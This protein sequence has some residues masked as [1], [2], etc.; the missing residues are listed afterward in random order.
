MKDNNPMT[1]PRKKRNI[2]QPPDNTP[3]N[4]LRRDTR[5]ETLPMTLDSVKVEQEARRI[6]R[7]AIATNDGWSNAMAG[8]SGMMDKRSKTEYG[9]FQ[10]V[11]DIELEC[12]YFGDG[13]GAAIVDML[14]EDMTKEWIEIAAEGSTE[15]GG[16]EDDVSEQTKTDIETV[17]GELERLDAET[18]YCEALKWARLYGGSCLVIGVLDGK[19][20]DQPLNLNRIQDIDYL[21]VVDRS[22]IYLASSIFQMDPMKHGFGEPIILRMI[23]YVGTR[24]IYQDVHV[25]R[26]ILFKGRKVPAGATLELNAWER[27]WGLSE[28]QMCYE[29]LRDWGGMME[30][31]VNII[32]EAVIGKYTI[33]NLANLLATGQEAQI[34]TRMEIINMTKSVIHAVLL[35]EGESYERDVVNLS[36]IKEVLEFGMLNLSAATGYPITKLFGRSPSGLNATGDGDRDIYYDKVASAQKVKLKPGLRQLINIICAWKKIKTPLSVNF[37]PLIQATDAELGDI[38]L[39]EAQ[40]DFYVAQKWNQC[41]QAGIVTPEFAFD[42]M[43]GDMNIAFDGETM[44]KLPDVEEV[45]EKKVT[46]D[47]S[48]TSVPKN[49]VPPTKLGRVGL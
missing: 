14:A 35:G 38:A 32:Y 48:D 15:D 46:I 17:K 24:T 16:E 37:N 42:Q 4:K 7:E 10:V 45:G 22:D 33:A 29:R 12:I 31:L 13:L 27:F 30:S 11:T 28:I 34:T 8:L 36:G 25:S 23:F 49:K 21:R 3:K 18:K 9:S 6:I 47:P 19:T 41:I 43:F 40:A 39:K 5:K 2:K 20:L 1:M 44:P 26:C